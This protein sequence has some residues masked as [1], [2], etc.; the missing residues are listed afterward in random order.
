V[1]NNP[2]PPRQAIIGDPWGQAPAV[3]SM[4]PA[5]IASTLG[6]SYSPFL[7]LP[8]GQSSLWPQASPTGLVLSPQREL[9]SLSFLPSQ[10]DI[11]LFHYR[12]G[13]VTIFLL[14]YVD[15]IIVASSSS[16]VVAALLRDLKDNFALKDLGPLRYF[17]GI[18][19]QHTSDGLHLSQTKHTTNILTR[20]GMLSCKGVTTLLPVNSKLSTFEGDPLGPDDATKY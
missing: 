7:S 16:A 20:A 2:N 15:D 12:N 10:A 1:A 6:R 11:S 14:V 8:T 18:E 4:P 19:V 17:L 3:I 5:M 9:Q 13:S